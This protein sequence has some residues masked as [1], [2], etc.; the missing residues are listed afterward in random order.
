MKCPGQDSRYW[1]PGDIFEVK[2]PECRHEVEFF[3]DD[4]ARVCKKCGHRFL[5]PHIDFGCA[6]Y[7]GFA[8]Q[9]TGSLPPELS[10]QR[11]DLLKDRV[12]LE[13]KRYF[14]NDFKRVRHAI[15][16]ARYAEAIGKKEGADLAVILSAA[17]LLEVGLWKTGEENVS[18]SPGFPSGEPLSVVRDILMKLEAREDLIEEVIHIISSHLHTRSEESINFKSV[19]DARIL[20]V[21]EESREKE[22]ADWRELA[23]SMSVRLLTKSGRKLGKTIRAEHNEKGG[24]IHA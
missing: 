20:A 3:K 10:P 23:D 8:A 2:C 14:Q 18:M 15:R 24:L 5:N 6:L 9:C 7:C 22:A 12:A 1:K 11:E 16:V 21:L 17:Y 4:T 19:H 13:M